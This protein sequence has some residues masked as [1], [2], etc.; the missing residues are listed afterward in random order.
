MTVTVPVQEDSVKSQSLRAGSE[1][2]KE[3]ERER[4][5]DSKETIRETGEREHPVQ[6]DSVKKYIFINYRKNNERSHSRVRN[7]KK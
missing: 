4:E 1:Q 2:G 3:R 5:R 6:E 7:K